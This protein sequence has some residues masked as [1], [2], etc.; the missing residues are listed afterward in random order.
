M[1]FRSKLEDLMVAEELDF[2]PTPGFGKYRRFLE[3]TIP[4][5]AKMN[6]NLLEFLIKKY[7][8]EGDTILDPMAGT[9]SLGVVASLLGRNA[10]Q[11][12]LEP[13]FYEWM[14]KARENVESHPTLT[15]KGRIINI[16]GDARRLSELLG[17]IDAVIT[18][19]P[20]AD[21]Y[22]GG[23]DPEKRKE[24]IIKAGYNPEDYL[25]GR[26]RNAVLKH[27]SDV[28]V[29]V[30]SP[31]YAETISNKA[32]GPT[33]VEKVGVST[34]TARQYSDSGGNIGNLPLGN[35]DAIITSPPY[36]SSLEGTT[37]HTRGGIAS[38]DPKLAQSGTY[39]VMETGEL[40]ETILRP[41]AFGRTDPKAGGPYG[42]SLAH[43]YSPNPGNIGNLDSSEQDY[44]L[45]EKEKGLDTLYARLTRNGKPTYLSE[46]LKVYHEMYKVL[47]PGGLAIVVVKPY[48]RNKKI[49][50]L[51]YY[52][53]LLMERVGFKLEKLYKLRLSN[54][55]FWRILYY[56]RYPDVP[57][58]A[59]EY[60]IVMK[61]QSSG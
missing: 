34:I 4:H 22:L 59:H 30:T 21:S 19:P 8:R 57:R 24:R 9:G 41:R 1:E 33:R 37:R 15:P 25:G 6:T 16:L 55:S 2:E 23:G 20:Y 58:I 27:Y 36:A 46:M 44:V 32:G 42:S 39:S 56:K 43:P 47:K 17:T 60:V 31:P 13:R 48:I 49:I 26:A 28:D 5:P 51:P 53:Y 50:D 61:K 18:S 54:M 14:E 52:T 11:V 3:H 12:E 29:I 38:R 10:I 45:L 40:D 7:T 35:V